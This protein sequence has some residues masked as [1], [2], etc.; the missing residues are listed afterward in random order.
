MLEAFFNAVLEGTLKV[1]LESILKATSSL[2]VVL[3][4]VQMLFKGLF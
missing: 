4:D 2:K 3:E 1:M